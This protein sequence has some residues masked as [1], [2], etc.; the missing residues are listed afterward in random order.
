LSE[1]LTTSG[2]PGHVLKKLQV[3]IAC[4]FCGTGNEK[5]NKREV[6]NVTLKIGIGEKS[7]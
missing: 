7:L 3:S 6:E 1:D 5:W 2:K 4:L